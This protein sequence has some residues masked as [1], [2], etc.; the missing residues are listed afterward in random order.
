MAKFLKENYPE[1]LEEGIW[2]PTNSDYACYIPIEEEK[3]TLVKADV[4]ELAF[5]TSVEIVYENWVLAGTDRNLGYSSRV[6]HNVSNTISVSDWDTTFDYIYEN[7]KNFCGLS[8][9]S[10]T[11]DKIYKQAPFVEVLTLHELIGTYGNATIFASGLIVD[12]LHSF[13]NDLWDVCSAVTDRNFQLTGDRITTLVKR[14]IISRIKKFS[15]NYF[16]GDMNKT[17]D[18]IKD[19]HLYHKWVKITRAL[20]N[21]PVDFNLI[22][23]TEKYLQADEI[24]ANSCAGGACEVNF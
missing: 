24:S 16:N 17:I 9:L 23:Y 10:D 11:G 15:K 20:K 21:K 4:N 2:S 7:R 18:C 13:N 22:N 8:F 3:N 14:D 6:T 1:L 19:I 12:A 5:L